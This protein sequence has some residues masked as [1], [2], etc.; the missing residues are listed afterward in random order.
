MGY[1]HAYFNTKIGA[2]DKL[3]ALAKNAWEE[4]NL[5]AFVLMVL[6][7]LFCTILGELLTPIDFTYGAIMWHKDAVYRDVLEDLADELMLD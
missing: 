7:T 3:L 4:R 2:T 1:I 5:V 6:W